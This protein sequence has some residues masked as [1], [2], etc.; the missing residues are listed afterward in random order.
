MPAAAIPF[1]AVAHPSLKGG[2]SKLR[3]TAGQG[4]LSPQQIGS[5]AVMC[6]NALAA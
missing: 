3:L 5:D 6:A 1:H 4:V 2:E